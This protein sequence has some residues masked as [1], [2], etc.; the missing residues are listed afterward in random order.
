[1]IFPN[2][3]LLPFYG[4]CLE[5]EIIFYFKIPVESS[6]IKIDIVAVLYICIVQSL[7]VMKDI[8]F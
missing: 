1:M 5:G 6:K 4:K 3:Y 8:L 2:I 7:N